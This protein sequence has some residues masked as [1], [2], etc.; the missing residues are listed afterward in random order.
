[1]ASFET[2]LRKLSGPTG[3]RVAIA[4]GGAASFVVIAMS[5]E[6]RGSGASEGIAETG[7][8]PDV[9][10]AGIGLENGSL[11]SLVGSGLTVTVLA[12]PAGVRYRVVDDATGDALLDGAKAGVVDRALPELGLERLMS[13]GLMLADTPLD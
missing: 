10:S 5:V 9:L 12:S 13:D 1:M 11:G 2:I 6:P 3:R 7:G 8:P 4:L